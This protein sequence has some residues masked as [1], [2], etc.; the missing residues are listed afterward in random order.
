MIK[1]APSLLSAD[2]AR[3]AEAVE[4][5][6]DH[7]DYIHCDVMDGHFVPNLTFGAPVVAAVKKTSSLPLDVHLMIET[8]GRWVDDYRRAGLDQNDFL[9]FHYEAEEHPRHVIAHIRDAGIKPGIAVKPKTGFEAFKYL[10][11]LVD[12][13]LI[14]TVEP[15]FGGQKFM[16]DVLSKVQLTRRASDAVIIGIDGGI[17]C[18]TAPEAVNAGAN[19]LVAGNAVFGKADPVSAI[20]DIRNSIESR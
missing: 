4:L 15:G 3:L 16:Q 5:I 13:V 19:L 2:M 6:S 9:T 7:A 10:I 18:S 11:E 20:K 1:I 8:P 12:Q 17:D 14:M